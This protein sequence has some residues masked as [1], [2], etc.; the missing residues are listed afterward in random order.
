MEIATYMWALSGG[1]RWASDLISDEKILLLQKLREF[2]LLGEATAISIR[3][4][5]PLA[6]KNKAKFKPGE[7][8]FACIRYRPPCR[9]HANSSTRPNTRAV[10]PQRYKEI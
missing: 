9:M 5:A 4:F 2:V 1:A 3:A 7:N 10:V 8:D 6:K